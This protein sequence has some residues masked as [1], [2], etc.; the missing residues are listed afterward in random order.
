M[1]ITVQ[2]GPPPSP[3][4]VAETRRLIQLAESVLPRTREV[5]EKWRNGLALLSGV[6]V[7]AGVV[8]GR[9]S[10]QDVAS[11]YRIAVGVLLAVAVVLGIVSLVLAMLASFGWPSPVTVHRSADLAAW[12]RR[13]SR[14]A[15]AR[16]R[17][18]MAGSVAFVSLLVAAIAVTWYAPAKA[19]YV[20]VV[21]ED[22]SSQCGKRLTSD[23]G[24]L[25]LQRR[26]ATVKID[27]LK[28]AS[29]APVDACT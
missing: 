10:I 29:V 22:G 16:L 26:D 15:V 4:E 2:P 24:M 8:K 17:W 7:A 14:R 9:D 20:K 1:P 11:G 25:K 19:T 12:E 3:Q 6:V 28:V 18:S 27:A 5:A 13:E 21:M 23:A